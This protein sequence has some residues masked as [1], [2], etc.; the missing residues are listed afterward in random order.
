MAD[1]QCNCVRC[2]VRRQISSQPTRKAAAEAAVR[3]IVLSGNEGGG[4]SI[5]EAILAGNPSSDQIAAI[6]AAAASDAYN[7]YVEP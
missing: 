2:F 5:S 1:K 7:D 3:L 6:A 4:T